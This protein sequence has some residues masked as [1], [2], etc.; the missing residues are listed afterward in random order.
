[1]FICLLS[2][3]D[4]KI[5]RS[6]VSSHVIPKEPEKEREKK[7]GRKE[8]GTLTKERKRKAQNHQ[9]QISAAHF[10]TFV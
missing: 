4:V 7:E 1:M 9:N 10:L 5:D 2:D 3:E 8:E 6:T